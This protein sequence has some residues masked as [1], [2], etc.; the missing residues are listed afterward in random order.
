MR[1][2]SKIFISSF[3]LFALFFNV[4]GC[5]FVELNHRNAL[6][7][8][9]RSSLNEQLTMSLGLESTGELLSKNYR[10]E[11]EFFYDYLG[12]YFQNYLNYYRDSNIKHEIRDLDNNLIYG[13]ESSIYISNRIELNVPLDS[14][15]KCIIREV[16]GEDYIY[17]TNA[18]NIGE[19]KY[20]Y[21]YIKNISHLYD[22]RE[23]QYNL[24]I[25]INV[26]VIII[27]ALVLYLVIKII[28]KPIEE[29]IES[30][31]IISS[32]NYSKRVE[33]KSS[34][35]IGELGKSFNNMADEV[36]GKINELERS[37]KSKEDFIQGFTHEMKTPLTSIIGYAEFLRDTKFNEENMIMGMNYIYNEAKRLEILSTK[38][39]DM[40]YLDGINKE[41]KRES[42]KNIYTELE[43][44]IIDKIEEKNIKLKTEIDDIY[45][46][47]D[48]ELIK[49][50]ITNLINNSIKAS[51]ENKEIRIKCYKNKIEEF[52]FIVEDEGCGIEPDYTERI[53]EPFFMID[54]ARTRKNN[55]AGLGLSICSKIVKFHGGSIKV[56]SSIGIGTKIIIS[57]LNVTT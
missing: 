41:L 3:I 50:L 9:V 27:L 42:I 37:S 57:F 22:S 12:A 29:L 32:G 7:R 28:T 33:I 40:L 31:E 43:P 13:R 15:R 5:Y 26:V 56:N 44:Y 54:K 35:E 55:G 34:D 10:L 49:I 47:V 25:I 30:T 16:S 52:I 11:K 1:L 21:T 24:F 6:K 20:K 53:F 4:G 23:E 51:E 8:E 46:N 36:E 48:K 2:W 38:L 19:K 14:E 18:M 17:I 39:M 45:V